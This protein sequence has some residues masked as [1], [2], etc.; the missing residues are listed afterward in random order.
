M[1]KYDKFKSLSKSFSVFLVKGIILNDLL[2][3]RERWPHILIINEVI[4]ISDDAIWFF[5]LFQK[6]F[7]DSLLIPLQRFN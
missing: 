3:F 6:R 4:Q 2:L 7:L 1:K 5:L